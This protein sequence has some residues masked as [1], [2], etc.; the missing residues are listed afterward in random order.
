MKLKFSYIYLFLLPIFFWECSPGKRTFNNKDGSSIGTLLIFPN[1]SNIK[2][3][4]IGDKQVRS[5]SFSQDAENEIRG[6][7]IKYIPSTVKTKYLECNDKLGEEIVNSNIH[8]IR[9]VKGSSFPSKVNAPKFLLNI[10]D[11]LGENYGLF[12][13]QSGFTRTLENLKKQ[14]FKRKT[15][16]IASLGIYDTEPNSSYSIMIGVIVDKKRGKVSMYKELYWR[17]RNPNEEVVIR[18]QVRDIILSYFQTSN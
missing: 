3:I 10:L 13:F 8:L 7:L 17:N 4:E 9:A 5:E 14:Y 1:Y 2:V 15:I 6:Q 11:S 16:E 12:I 18:S